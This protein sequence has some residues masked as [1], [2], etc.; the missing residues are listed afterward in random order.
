[1]HI[2]DAQKADPTGDAGSSIDDRS[3]TEE[4]RVT[5]W[6]GRRPWLAVSAAIIAMA[7]SLA[8]AGGADLPAPPSPAY[9]APAVVPVAPIADFYDPYRSEVRFGVF[10]HGI[11]G[12]EKG[13]IDLNP[14]FVF[15]RLPFWRTE[16]WNVLVPRP[17]LGGLINLE[18]RTSSFYAGAL[19][20]V[21]LPYRTFFEFFVDADKHNGYENFPPAGRAG[22]GC[23]L[24][25]HVG[26]SLG[27]NISQH[28]NV[29]LTFDHLSNGKH[30]FGTAC[31]GLGTSTPNPGINDWGARVGYAF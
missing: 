11:G 17:H 22:L 19:W 29:M 28:W 5:D 23:P 12:V 27:Y 15:P 24:L 21:P 20:S 4:M 6:L 9:P 25:F 16:W 3:G 7:T 30:V 14:E 1:V 13:T 2:L 8:P 18:G 10:A 31:E 26:G